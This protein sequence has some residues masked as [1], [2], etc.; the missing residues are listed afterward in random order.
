MHILVIDD[1]QVITDLITY[2]FQSEVSHISSASSFQE[3]LK[4]LETYPIDLIFMDFSLPDTDHLEHLQHIRNLMDLNTVPIIMLTSNREVQLE[5]LQYGAN[6]F[7][8]KPFE[9]KEL[10]AR[11]KNYLEIYKHKKSLEH[12]KVDLE[13][14]ILEQNRQLKAAL[15]EKHQAEIEIC[16]RLGHAAEF[17]D[18]ETGIHIRRMSQMC[19]HLA[20]LIGLGEE[21]C[22]IVLNASK[23]HDIGK[24]GID[25]TILKKPGRLSPQEYATMQNHSLIGA[26]LLNS[27]GVFPLLEAARLI[28]LEHH[29]HF[30]G[31]GYP[32]GKKGM[33]IHLYARIVAIVDVF[34]AL[35]S[36]RIY[37]NAFSI[38]QAIEILKEGR[39]TH[40]DPALL[41]LFL[42]HIDLFIDIAKNFPD[43]TLN[44][45]KGEVS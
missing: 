29:E 34:D 35:I 14:E 37:K 25:D 18:I 38:S 5:A 3:S 41:D 42:E 1:D 23:L 19:A 21:E 26:S 45:H 36:K 15:D 28:A 9:L 8:S 6:D 33:E 20:R 30:D 44:T 43:D 32:H 17:R 31:S 22:A 10:I 11:S 39:G 27:D 12:K 13:Y 24:V 40:F 16:N 4:I 7:V 2:A